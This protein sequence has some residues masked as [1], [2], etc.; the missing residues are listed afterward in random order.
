M[1]IWFAPSECF[2]V[3]RNVQNRIG[4]SLSD[5]RK[6]DMFAVRAFT[7]RQGIHPEGSALTDSTVISYD[8]VSSRNTAGPRGR[9]GWSAEE[10]TP[11]I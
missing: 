9:P 7:A 3:K 4:L 1:R 10:K 6:H 5:N 8:N 2:Q 11:K